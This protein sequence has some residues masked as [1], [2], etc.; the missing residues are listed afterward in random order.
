MKKISAQLLAYLQA[1]TGI[2]SRFDL[3]Q[4]ILPNGQQILSTNAQQDIT[5]G[6]YTYR[7]AQ[8]GAWERGNVISVADFS[9]ESHAMELSVV[10]GSSVLYPGSSEPLMSV[11][12]AGLFDGAT[13]NVNTV[14]MQPGTWGDVIGALSLFAG[15]IVNVQELGRSK[16]QFE[17]RDWMYL[18]NLKIPQRIIQPSC[19]H[20]LFDP[21]CTLS[22]TAFGLANT[23]G[24]GST[25]SVIQAGAAWPTTD[26]LGNSTASPYFQQGK[27]IFTSGQNVGLAAQVVT[28]GAN[29]SLTL[30]APLIF[31]VATGDAFTAYPGCDKQ[32]A[33]CTGKFQN[34]IHFGGMLFV[35]P[36]ETVTG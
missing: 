28:E 10:A 11:I 34:Q 17:V 25:Q 36:P 13:V 18:L 21:S 14:Y 12:W 35:P 9:L 26:H 5:Y 24:A 27:I 31:P 22:Q 1:S 23:V 6:G 16:A 7:A 33:T 30:M 8:Y 4:I 3:F 19:P 29:G 2:V 20:T 32:L 15:S